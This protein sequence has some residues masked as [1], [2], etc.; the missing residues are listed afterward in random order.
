M[1]VANI[2]ELEDYVFSR[3][4]ARSHWVML[5]SYQVPIFQSL[6]AYLSQKDWIKD[7]ITKNNVRIFVPEND[8]PRIIVINKLFLPIEVL[9]IFFAAA[10]ATDQAEL[11]KNKNDDQDIIILCSPSDFRVHSVAT[12]MALRFEQWKIDH[13]VP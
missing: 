9:A 10:G 4:V 13:R 5:E 2:R 6:M 11:L 7:E 8:L 1:D 3:L 12:G